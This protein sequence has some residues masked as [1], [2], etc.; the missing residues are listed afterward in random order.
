[1]PL[2][3]LLAARNLVSHRVRNLVVGLISLLG[4]SLVIVTLT[5]LDG[6]ETAMKKSITGSVAGNF[7]LYDHQAK[8]PLVLM[9]GGL[10]AV[11]DVG[12][13]KNFANIRAKIEQTPGV[14]A[15]IPMGFDIAAIVTPGGFER[16]LQRLKTVLESNPPQSPG[17]TA[18]ISHVQSLAKR[19]VDEVKQRESISGAR[20]EYDDQ[21][22]KLS[23]VLEDDFW[24]NITQDSREAQEYLETQIAPIAGSEKRLIFRYLGTDFQKFGQHFSGFKIVKGQTV[25]EGKRGFLFSDFYYERQVKHR[26]ARLFDE[27][28]EFIKDGELIKNNAGQKARVARMV[29]QW[30][31]IARELDK[32]EAS[33]LKTALNDYLAPESV[34]SL[35]EL[36][37][38]F[39][40]VDDN[41]YQERHQLFYEL[42]AP[43]IELYAFKPNDIISLDSFTKNGFARSA[44]VRF[45]GTYQFSGLEDSI[46]AGVYNLTDLVTFQHL[47]GVMTD[48]DRAELAALRSKIDLVDVRSEDAEEALFGDAA[49]T[50]TANISDL[51]VGQITEGSFEGQHVRGLSEEILPNQLSQGYILN[52]AVILDKHTPETQAK[53]QL[54]S[55]IRTHN[56]P[57]QLADWRSVGGLFGQFIVVIRLVLYAALVIMFCVAIVIIN[58]ALVMTTIERTAEIG[59]FR[60]IGAQRW[61]VVTMFFIETLML[62]CV[63]GLFGC[64][65]GGGIVLW[66]QLFGL[67]APNIGLRFLFGG[68]ALFPELALVHLLVGFGVILLVVVLSTIYPAY[69]GASVAPIEAMRAEE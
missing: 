38:T 47:S 9:G 43:N 62:S 58:N 17:V 44:N 18:A 59:T 4:T 13:I 34:L 63:S 51:D 56:L 6:V 42:V 29:Q 53:A 45:Y 52:A 10:I 66:W 50:I 48:D 39:L 64:L 40:N 8:E 33:T 54:E 41:S 32:A 69:L 7:Q 30:S 3:I 27:I 67:A 60:A 19:F 16:A 23:K 24:T 37:Q 35:K 5:V 31:R 22:H 28:G 14:K 65:V 68:P 12:H 20:L 26:V 15:L 57:V 25:P 1:M 46:L 2:L 55:T 49:E 61:Q 36:I 21:L 11:P